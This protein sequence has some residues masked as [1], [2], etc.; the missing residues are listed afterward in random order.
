MIILI[1]CGVPREHLKNLP[2]D[3]LELITTDY[4]GLCAVACDSFSLARVHYN[5]KNHLRNQKKWQLKRGHGGQGMGPLKSR[6][7]YCELCDVEITSKV[8]SQSHYSGKSHRAIVE[9]RRNPKNPILVQPGM[10][11]RIKQLVRREKRFLVSDQVDSAEAAL[12]DLIDIKDRI[13]AELHC[14]IC[15]TFVTCTEQMTL[16]LNGKKH[17]NKEK[18]HILK[19][20]KGEASGNDAADK[21]TANNDDDLLRTLDRV[22]EKLP[23][24]EDEDLR[25]DE[26][27]E[28]EDAAEEDWEKSGEKW[29]EP[30]TLC[31]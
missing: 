7:L 18:Q 16:H 6:D 24:I 13:P 29:D 25:K 19:M 3:L 12:S 14:D 9:G 10:E 21:S 23:P 22:L 17:L 2:R 31:S 28:G 8:H 27:V 15:K 1:E 26:A 5:S 11:D 30:E 20:M 4:C